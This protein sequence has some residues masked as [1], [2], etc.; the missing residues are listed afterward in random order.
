MVYYIV[1]LIAVGIN[2][3]LVWGFFWV[4][5]LGMPV[6][7]TVREYFPMVAGKN[8]FLL[9]TMVVMGFFVAVGVSPLVDMIIRWVKGYR[10]L[11]RDE[12]DFFEAAYDEVMDKLGV[13]RRSFTVYAID[14]TTTDSDHLGFSS[15]AFSRRV[16]KRLVQGEI[17]ALVAHEVAHLEMGH[18]VQ[19][20]VFFAVN[21]LGQMALWF[22]KR[23]L[24]VF[25]NVY[26]LDLPFVSWFGILGV[27]CFKMFGW[28]IEFF[29]V[30][31]LIIGAIIGF[32]MNEYAA[33]RFVVEMGYGKGLY[34]YLLD[35]LD[36]ET[37]APSAD[38]KVLKWAKGMIWP[39]TGK[40]LA[41]IEK[42]LD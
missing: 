15:I 2:A 11:L 33:D 34:S 3:G 7:N 27:G 32:R 10:P 23:F 6:V 14:D 16:L 26:G 19:V 8:V 9:L 40:R 1:N 41:E 31:P 24:V 17:K 22:S 39:S 42:F 25:K 37:K 36:T 28:L 35:K 13:D 20:R 21:L 12:R 18:G 5:N 38:W 4:L 30:F 29:L